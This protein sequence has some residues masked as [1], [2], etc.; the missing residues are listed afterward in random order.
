MNMSTYIVSLSP[1]S[2]DYKWKF[3]GRS[4]GS[5]FFCLPSHP[6]QIGTMAWRNKSFDHS[7]LIEQGLQLR[8]QLRNC[9]LNITGIPF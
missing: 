2:F 4:P 1:E 8:G 3:I 9:C 5:P 6:E 7:N